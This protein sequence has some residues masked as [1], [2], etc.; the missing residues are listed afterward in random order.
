MHDL[1]VFRHSGLKLDPNLLVLG[2]KGYM[3]ISKDHLMSRTPHRKPR[4]G[5]LTPEQKLHN[6]TL[7]SLRM[8]VEHVIRQ[9]KVFRILASIYRNRRRRFGLRLN[10]IAALCNMDRADR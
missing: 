10:L 5:H 2:D 3:G 8:T 4:K 6:R 1:R 7:A 9:L